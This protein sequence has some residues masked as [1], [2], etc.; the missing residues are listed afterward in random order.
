VANRVQKKMGDALGYGC[1]MLTRKDKY[2][3]LAGNDGIVNNNKS[4]V[5]SSSAPAAPGTKTN[6]N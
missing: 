5:P 4:A 1:T 2:L 3:V 6:N